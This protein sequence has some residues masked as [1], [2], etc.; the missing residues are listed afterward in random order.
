MVIVVTFVVG[1]LV[2]GTV[3]N[4]GGAEAPRAPVAATAPPA[5]PGG[6]PVAE[7]KMI[8]TIKFG[9][10]EVVLPPNQEVTVRAD[11][12]DGAVSHNWAA[13]MDSSA[14]ELI[15]RTDI[16]RAPCV[17]QVTLATPAPGEYFFRCD[18]HPTQMVGKLIVQ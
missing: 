7:V 6:A 16:C 2:G 1:V 8:P 17:E 9:T 18:V 13:Y 5:S 15:A 4:D 3:G 14:E 11:N 12:Q 10:N